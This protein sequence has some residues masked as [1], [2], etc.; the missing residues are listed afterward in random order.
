MRIPAYLN[1]LII[2]VLFL[3]GFY[4]IVTYLF[5]NLKYKI[6]T[7]RKLKLYKAISVGFQ[8]ATVDSMTDLTNLYKGVYNLGTDDTSHI[9]G[10]TRILRQYLV[11]LIS[12]NHLDTAEILK[13]KEKANGLLKQIESDIPF[14]DLPT[15]ERNLILDIQHT[16]NYDDKSIALQKI[17]ELAGQIEIRQNALKSLQRSN[18]WSIPLAIIGLVLTLFF[19]VVSLIQI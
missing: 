12:E 5:F 4:V 11:S 1:N 3:G 18:R 17:Q 19:G 9:P 13:L 8:N 16:L 2:A 15:T 7:K 6:E 14:A 10:L